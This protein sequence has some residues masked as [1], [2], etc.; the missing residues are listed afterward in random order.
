M[1]YNFL[2]DGHLEINAFVLF[3]CI[4]N[5]IYRLMEQE[6][7][8]PLNGMSSSTQYEDGDCVQLVNLRPLNGGY[9]PVAPRKTIGI[10]DRNYDILFLHQNGD[11][12]NWIGVVHTSKGSDIYWDIL[13]EPKAIQTNFDINIESIEQTGNM[14]TLVTRYDLYYIIYINDIYRYL[15]KMPELPEVEFKIANQADFV[16]VPPVYLKSRTVRLSD[17]LGR[18][19]VIDSTATNRELMVTAT[20]AAV[21]KAIT[22]ITEGYKDSSHKTIDGIP[23]LFDAHF[24]RYAFRMIDGS[25]SRHSAPILIMPPAALCENDSPGTTNHKDKF[26]EE[27]V[28]ASMKYG[29]IQVGDDFIYIGESYVDVK[30]Y[31]LELLYNT[32]LPADSNWKYFI[33]SVDVFIS[34]PLG[35][36]S[37]E[38]I[39]DIRSIAN[40]NLIKPVDSTV[41]EDVMECGNFY[42]LHS[43]P[44]NE[45]KNATTDFGDRVIV[46][47]K[48]SAFKK[49]EDVIYQEA[50]VDDPFS[51]HKMGAT[52]SY[53]YNHRLHLANIHSTLF[54]GFKPNMFECQNKASDA[55]YGNYNGYLYPGTNELP[56]DVY[57]FEVEINAGGKLHKVYSTGKRMYHQSLFLVPYLCYPDSRATSIS[58]WGKV[59]SV[60]VGSDGEWV[61][62]KTFPLRAH[63]FLN[64]AY[65]FDRSLEPITIDKD[66]TYSM[67]YVPKL[68][69]PVIYENKI[70]V[71]N[72]NNPMVFPAQNT[73][74]VGNGNVISMASNA[75]RISE[76][77]FGQFPLYVF[78]TQG[79]YSLEVGTGDTIYSTSSASS[80]VVT[81][82]KVAIPMVMGVMF[83]TD[84]GLSIINGQQIIEL[85]EQLFETFSPLN[86]AIPDSVKGIIH[87]LP[88]MSF[89]EYIRGADYI[90]YN[91]Y[92][93]EVI[94]SKKGVGF[95]YVLNMTSKQYYQSTERIDVIA[96][97]TFPQTI[98]LGDMKLKDFEFASLDAN[99]EEERIDVSFVLRPLRFGTPH[100]KW[101][102][103]QQLIGQY[104]DAKPLLFMGQSGMDGVSFKLS[105]GAAPTQRTDYASLTT[106]LMP[107]NKYNY[108]IFCFGGTLS[109]RT[110]IHE[111]ISIVQGEYNAK[112]MI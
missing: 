109:P 75:I 10:T 30:Y 97:N 26:K 28:N 50:M 57:V 92:Q 71:S 88:K 38:R 49:I 59:N 6:V 62:L 101:V 106:R 103:K 33:E 91:H 11:Y 55:I 80:Y 81:T 41:L 4:I 112:L 64:L 63:R 77:Q 18:D 22:D 44:I 104:Y 60:G 105:N 43:I 7:R 14:L 89:A 65:Y 39:K 15:G 111:L 66:K 45:I 42:L 73:Y 86:I 48:Q 40:A 53:S 90:A 82:S 3:A 2:H 12:K 5:Q 51:H 47:N 69:A 21:N 32:Y 36:S 74:T 87:D 70:K 56:F 19:D 8:T 16:V 13:N 37:I 9:T 76:G 84:R 52:T 100:I 27:K 107:K 99:G 17:I 95:N 85:S 29:Y 68:T 35:L 24:V 1:R 34:A 72:L 61:K 79:V 46:P 98:A 25:L 67:V 58:V 93:N 102:Q 110:R 96:Q 23:A 83:T 54:E 108:F 78:T 20:K 94:V 31:F